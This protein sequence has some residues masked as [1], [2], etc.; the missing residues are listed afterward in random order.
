MS[1]LFICVFQNICLFHLHRQI[2]LHNIVHNIP[3]LPFTIIN[4]CGHTSSSTSNNDQ[5]SKM[6][7]NFI[8]EF[9]NWTI[10]FVDFSVLFASFLFYWSLVLPLFLYLFYTYF[11][12]ICFEWGLIGKEQGDGKVLN[13]G[14]VWIYENMH[15]PNLIKLYT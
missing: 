1:V 7:I 10:G 9:K 3:L 15:L 11:G 12:F 14:G 6:I 4:I 2:K 8:E 5:S 13:L